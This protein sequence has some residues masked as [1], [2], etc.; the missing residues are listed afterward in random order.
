MNHQLND[1]A[2]TIGTSDWVKKRNVN[3]KNKAH[4]ENGDKSSGRKANKVNAKWE[5]G[6]PLGG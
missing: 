5:H 1:V 4:C 6:R 2:D 3:E